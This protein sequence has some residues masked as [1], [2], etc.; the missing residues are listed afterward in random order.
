M[1]DLL[2]R[3][4]NSKLRPL[5]PY[6]HLQG[7]A[8]ANGSARIHGLW[9]RATNSPLADIYI[10]LRPLFKMSRPQDGR[11]H[12]LIAGTLLSNVDR[13]LSRTLRRFSIMAPHLATSQYAM[14]H[15]TLVN[16]SLK[17][18]DIATAVGYNDRAIHRIRSNV[19]HFGTTKVPPNS[20]GRRRRITPLM[21]DTLRERLV[22]K[23]G[24]HLDEMIVFLWDNL[25]YGLCK[26]EF[27]CKI[28]QF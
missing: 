3:Y 6:L 13:E 14:I 19:R 7:N 16:G 23:P 28:H 9:A 17:G 20:V 12:P 5:H 21:L 10:A 11:K 18:V 27:R 22:E 1:I 15:D 25:P 2:R 26:C 8:R 24:M 4:S